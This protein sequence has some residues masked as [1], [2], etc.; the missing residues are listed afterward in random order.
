MDWHVGDRFIYHYTKNGIQDHEGWHGTIESLDEDGCY[1]YFDE[2]PTAVR[3]NIVYFFNKQPE[4]AC[5]A[6]D[7]SEFL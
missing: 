2:K 6:V 4:S 1:A 3:P 5:V 7:V